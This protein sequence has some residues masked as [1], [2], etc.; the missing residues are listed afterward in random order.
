MSMKKDT[1]W[2]PNWKDSSRYPDSENT[3][4]YQWAW[5]FLRR[6]PE[7]Q[8]DYEIYSC[9]LECKPKDKDFDEK[10]DKKL[11]LEDKYSF[12]PLAPPDKDDPFSRYRHGWDVLKVPMFKAH[13]VWGENPE[14]GE[15]DNLF[16]YDLSPSQ[17][18][19]VFDL[20]EPR[21]KQIDF[22]NL[23]FNQL[24]GAYKPPGFKSRFHDYADHLRILDAKAA[25]ATHLEI[26]REM[27]PRKIESV[28]KESARIF[29]REKLKNAK[30]LR[31]INYL[32]L[33]SI[34]NLP[35]PR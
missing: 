14:N 33:A 5:E 3:T 2:L 10:Y 32:R 12:S 27:F 13:V 21:Q 24:R 19:I 25:G 26:L 29:I 11:I 4:A 28:G 7:Y 15:I 1:P 23:M 9:C 22:V 30:K 8:E 20:A 34:K 31:D 6:N 17:F 16:S 18:G 35:K